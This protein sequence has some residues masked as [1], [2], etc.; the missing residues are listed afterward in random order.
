MPKQL[1]RHLHV[2]PGEEGEQLACAPVIVGET[3]ELK[4]VLL[5]VVAIRLEQLPEHARLVDRLQEGKVAETA[6]LMGRHTKSFHRN[7]THAG[8]PDQRRPPGHRLACGLMNSPRAHLPL[9]M[10]DQKRRTSR[11]HNLQLH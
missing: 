8:P 10:R 3:I 9:S 4:P 11:G 7:A 5:E 6:L 1:L 2:G